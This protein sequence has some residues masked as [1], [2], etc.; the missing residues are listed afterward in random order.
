MSQ[1]TTSQGANG[2]SGQNGNTQH[3]PESNDH[4]T[5]RLP[6]RRTTPIYPTFGQA[7]TSITGGMTSARFD[8]EPGTDSL[9]N[10]YARAMNDEAMGPSTS[11][12]TASE[13]PDVQAIGGPVQTPDMPAV[14]APVRF[15]FQRSTSP[16]T[17]DHMNPQDAGDNPAGIRIQSSD[18]ALQPILRHVPRS[19]ITYSTNL[20][21]EP[22]SLAFEEADRRVRDRDSIVPLRSPTPYPARRSS[23]FDSFLDKYGDPD[24]SV[25]EEQ[26]SES[27]AD[28][29]DFRVHPR[30]RR[31]T[32]AIGAP[33]AWPLPAEPSTQQTE[34]TAVLSSPQGMYDTTSNL[35]RLRER[36]ASSHFEHLQGLS[37]RDR[38]RNSSIYSS[39]IDE[40][41]AR[42]ANSRTPFNQIGDPGPAMAS[43]PQSSSAQ[44]GSHRVPV[45]VSD[46]GTHVVQTQ[47]RDDIFE[48]S[49]SSGIGIALTSTN[50]AVVRYE[51]PS[52]VE[53]LLGVGAHVD[54]DAAWETT[55]GSN[56]QRN[57]A[58]QEVDY[59]AFSSSESLA[60]QATSTWD[61][62][63]TNMR[64]LAEAEREC[65]E[66]QAVRLGR[67]GL[68]G[69][70][71]EAPEDSMNIASWEEQVNAGPATSVA[72]QTFT[73]TTTPRVQQN[74]YFQQSLPGTSLLTRTPRTN[75]LQSDTIVNMSSE[76]ASENERATRLTQ[77]QDEIDRYGKLL[78]T[79][80]IVLP[81][82]SI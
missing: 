67:G 38:A 49:S 22:S 47:G 4:G 10:V 72:S 29:G 16:E 24:D 78:P 74:N 11:S 63:A 19:S 44:A 36:R 53:G 39:E 8:S 81:T 40:I 45:D 5:S 41:I 17:N 54:D 62:L 33:P 26:S 43:S 68:G 66:L 56:T 75:I 48:P 32:T 27:G 25:L 71:T 9:N 52:N 31:N 82:N 60:R 34:S 77:L 21:R 37:E 13:T 65:A 42:R 80:Q 20:P 50:D 57:S 18:V 59:A 79:D 64:C 28:A 2:D 76:T 6:V 70:Q 7:H 46:T 69:A 61:P 23:S 14:G 58:I 51:L 35:L 1:G 15:P 12:A 30:Q 3:S 55:Q 73:T